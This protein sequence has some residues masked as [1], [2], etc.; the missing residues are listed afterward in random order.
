[1]ENTKIILS[2]SDEAASFKTN[3]SGWVSRNGR[4]FGVDERIARYDGCTHVICEDCGKPTEKGCLVCSECKEKRDIKKYNALPNEEWNGVGAVY[5][6]SNDKYFWS[7]D[8]VDE[9]CYDEG[10]KVEDLRL[11]IC[12]PQYL[13]LLDH[14]DYGEDVLAED[15]E[16]P[17]KVVQAIEDFNKVIKNT[18]PVSWYPSNKAVAQRIE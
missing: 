1:M 9:F 15:G 8:E 10:I 5:S 7:W 4:F 16:L 17:D 13:P 12:T 18:E 11:V 14:S 6:E 2:T 3:I